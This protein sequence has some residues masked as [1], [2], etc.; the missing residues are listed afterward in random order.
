MPW[1]GLVTAQGGDLTSNQHGGRLN[2]RIYDNNAPSHALI[3]GQ[4]AQQPVFCP[5]DGDPIC[6]GSCVGHFAEDQRLP[7]PNQRGGRLEG[8]I[9]DNNALSHALIGGQFAQQADFCPPE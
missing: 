1:S 4:F 3:G 2:E 9:Y 7:D 8:R 5:P 6:P